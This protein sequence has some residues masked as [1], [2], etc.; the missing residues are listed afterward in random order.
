MASAWGGAFGSA[1]GDAWGSVAAEKG[2]GVRFIPI[3]VGAV[4]VKSLRLELRTGKVFA[5]GVSGVVPAAVTVAP[6]HVRIVAPL[7]DTT[8]AASVEI[9]GV[10][11]RIRANGASV[12][13]AGNIS[14][15]STR[16]RLRSGGSFVMAGSTCHVSTTRVPH[17]VGLATAAGV[18]NL[19]EEEIIAIFVANRSKCLLKGKKCVP[20]TRI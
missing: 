11:G 14:T 7:V 15:C 20:I 13:A 19:S 16:T 12:S 10:A 4:T 18:L 17:S 2:G 5:V 8:G 3:K 1:W 6:G 9:I